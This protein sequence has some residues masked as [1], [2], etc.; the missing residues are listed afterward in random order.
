M[1]CCLRGKMF[2]VFITYHKNSI[3]IYDFLFPC[4][5]TNHLMVNHYK[6]NIF[7]PVHIN[8]YKVENY[9]FVLKVVDTHKN[10]KNW[11]FYWY[12]D[13]NTSEF[14][15]CHFQMKIRHRLEEIFGF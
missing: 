5:V 3:T 1:L 9:R 11:S 2:N 14:S 15:R 13:L 7:L 6:R 8:V 10:G 12:I 4:L